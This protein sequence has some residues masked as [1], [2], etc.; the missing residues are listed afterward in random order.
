MS[1]NYYD[2]EDREQELEDNSGG[3]LRRQLEALIAKNE[4]LTKRLDEREATKAGESAT[5][6]LKSQGIDPVVLELVPE[7]AN[8]LE[9]AQK[10]TSLLGGQ[11]ADEQESHEIDSPE[12]TMAS[13]DDPALVAEREALAAMQDAQAAG[14]LSAAESNDLISKMDKITNEEELLTFFRQN[15]SIGG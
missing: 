9:W 3:G 4:E 8:P 6:H 1:G 12:V 2:S 14:S 15:G 11:R 5:E 10:Y 13:D 7:G